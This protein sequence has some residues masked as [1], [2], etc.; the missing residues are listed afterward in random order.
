M[1]LVVVVAVSD[2]YRPASDAFDFDRH[3]V[4]LARGDGY[5]PALPQFGGGASAF[6]PPAYPVALAAADVVT[7][8]PGDRAR[9]TI[10]LLVGALLGAA[11]VALVGLVGRRLFGDAVGLLSAAIAALWPPFLMIATSLLSENLFLPLML[12]ALLATLHWRRDPRARW[13]VAAGALTGLCALTRSN[14]IV[15]LLPLGLAVWTRRPRSL[16]PVAALVTVAVLVVLPW[17][18]RSTVV[19]D[20]PVTV[21]TQGGYAV[22]GIYND[23]ARDDPRWPWNWG[24]P[25][26]DPALARAVFAKPGLTEARADSRLRSRARAY[27]LDDPAVIAEAGWWNT[28]RL[29]NL[30]G[31]G[32]EEASARALGVNADAAKLA[33]YAFWLILP[34]AVVGAFSRAVRETPWW[35]WL[36]PALMALSAIFTAGG[37]TRYRLPEDPFVIW[38][39]ACAVVSLLRRATGRTASAKGA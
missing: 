36:V 34:L 8:N 30:Q 18:I 3:A 1:R 28:V 20:A 9:W 38:L 10:G 17:S 39:A 15:M 33:V 2:G 24:P 32:V 35:L 13:L 7:G 6:R 12:A 25:E 26:R 21:S 14:G 5:P 37:L 23:T 19:L 4:S 22:A 11:T 16:R 31:P 29:L 27:V